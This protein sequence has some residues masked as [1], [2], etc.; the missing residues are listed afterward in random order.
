MLRALYR[1]SIPQFLDRIE[2]RSVHQMLVAESAIAG[3]MPPSDGEINSWKRSLP[4]LAEVLQHPDFADDEIFIELLMPISSGRCDVLLTGRDA[5]GRAAAVIIELKQWTYVQLG[6]YPEHVQ[7]HNRVLL[8]PSVQVHGYV[9]HL[10]MFSGAFQRDDPEPLHLYGVVFLHNMPEGPGLEMLRS[11]KYFGEQPKRYPLFGSADADALRTFLRQRLVPGPG[12]DVATRIA[13]SPTETSPKLLEHIVAI[14]ERNEDW[15]LIDAQKTAYWAISSAT[16]QARETNQRRVI[17]VKGG[18]GTGKSVI[19]MQLLAHGARQGWRVV[20]AT[21]SKAFQTVLQAKMIKGSDALMKKI[22]GVR[23]LKELPVRDLF[24]TFSE[25][26]KI[27]SKVDNGHIKAPVDLI[28]ADEAHRLWEYRRQKFPN[29]TV[30]WLTKTPMVEEFLNSTRVAAFFLDDNQSVRPG[31]VGH[32]RVIIQ[33]A[34]RL[35]IPVEI[36]DLQ[37]QFRCGGSLEYTRWV[38]ALLGY[39]NTPPSLLP[40]DVQL[41]ED[42]PEAVHALE[43][44]RLHG[45]RCRIIAGYC[46]RWSKPLPGSTPEKPLL[47][48]DIQDPRFG[49]WSGPWIEKLSLI[50]I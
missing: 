3:L 44:A 43:T 23:H 31:E 25:A 46:W 5:G 6:H 7:A 28:V 49:G 17:I 13:A 29:G 18:P 21:G 42:M 33:H 48:H 12:D 40:Y 45:D 19:A 4:A 22:H 24:T 35:G 32:S 20:H 9:Q 11:R 8:H 10:R 27:A 16:T 39:T 26:A 34:Q 2:S 30:R 47:K 15:E 41:A 38:D 37:Q 1:S 50:H 14:I 36:V